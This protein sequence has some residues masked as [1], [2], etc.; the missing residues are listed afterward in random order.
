MASLKDLRGRISS[1]KAT[2][3]ITSAMKMVAA[4]K[5]RRAQEQAEAARPY[6][7][8][9]ER[10]LASLGQSVA[11]TPG[12]PPLLAGT[13]STQRHLI[14]LAT[15]DRGLC[16]GFNANLVR[17]AR[18]LIEQLQ[19]DGKD[20]H[21]LCVGRKGR[22]SLRRTYRALIKD[23]IEGI[24][25]RTVAFDEADGI[26]ARIRAG[27]SDGEFDVCHLIYAKFKSAISNEV[28]AQQLIPAPVPEV[29][30]EGADDLGGAVYEY[31]PSEEAILAD[32]LPRNISVQI[33]RALLENA[34]SEH[35]ARMAA[36]DN[37]TRNAG[38][39]IKSLT[40]TYNRTR[41]AM[42]T[43]ELIEIISGAEAV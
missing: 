36:M 17:R 2:Q 39:M 15:A 24:G 40:L 11:G 32:L 37:A 19:R 12:A 33:Y 30:S 4:A 16:G 25:R 3:K 10:M 28:T 5:L 26:A 9:M 31:E 29:G 42:I 23:T 34:A 18:Q 27:F 14:V 41:Q 22:D 20:V 21:V 38:D 35:G 1:V 7:E 43:K 13:G 8:R 6:A